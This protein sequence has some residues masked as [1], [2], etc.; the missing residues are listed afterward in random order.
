MRKALPHEKRKKSRDRS[1]SGRRHGKRTGPAVCRSPAVGR[2][3]GSVHKKVLQPWIARRGSLARKAKQSRQGKT[4]RPQSQDGRRERK[5]QPRRV[6]RGSGSLNELVAEKALQLLAE[7]P[8]QA[9]VGGA[10]APVE[11]TSVQPSSRWRS[12]S[13]SGVDSSRWRR[14]AWGELATRRRWRQAGAQ[15]RVRHGLRCNRPVSCGHSL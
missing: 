1:A 10:A 4:S 8:A 3:P 13:T 6:G 15:S 7:L 9:A 2:S 5:G 14:R 11:L 12:C